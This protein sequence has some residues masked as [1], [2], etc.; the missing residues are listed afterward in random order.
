[1]TSFAD[2]FDQVFTAR[3]IAR[4]RAVM[5]VYVQA[6]VSAQTIERAI[7]GFRITPES[8]DKLKAWAFVHHGIDDLDSDSLIRAPRKSRKSP[9]GAD[10]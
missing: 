9:R 10:V 1:M 8:A 4:K 5:T 7:S 6:D 3:G 2:I